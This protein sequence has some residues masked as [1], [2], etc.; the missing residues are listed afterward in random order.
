MDRLQE[1]SSESCRDTTDFPKRFVCELYGADWE[2]CTDER[3]T[4]SYE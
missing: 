4:H 1:G 3:Q 2:T